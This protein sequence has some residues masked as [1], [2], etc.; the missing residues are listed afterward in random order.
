MSNFRLIT[1][2]LIT[3]LF[4]VEGIVLYKKNVL[5]KIAGKIIK[6]KAEDYAKEKIEKIA[7]KII[8]KYLPKKVSDLQISDVAQNYT[9]FLYLDL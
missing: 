8:D 4:A 5:Q 7:E 1:L 9:N 2:A 3:L 6:N